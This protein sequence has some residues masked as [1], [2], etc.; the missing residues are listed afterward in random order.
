MMMICNHL[1]L[2]CIIWNV[3]LSASEALIC[4]F[5]AFE[6]D[7]LCLERLLLPH[8][9]TPAALFAS[10]ISW[11]LARR[12][13]EGLWFSTLDDFLEGEETW[14]TSGSDDQSYVRDK[15]HKEQETMLIRVLR[16]LQLIHVSDSAWLEGWLHDR[17]CTFWEDCTLRRATS[18]CAM[19]RSGSA[20]KGGRGA[21]GSGWCIILL[22]LAR[23]LSWVC[24]SPFLCVFSCILAVW[25]TLQMHHMP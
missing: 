14:N 1:N 24:R 13:P 10:Q 4:R 23:I 3:T 16:K 5:M 2:H 11:H 25:S 20:L 17:L 9:R 18:W 8:A 6:T 12:Q 21:L 15:V 19:V 7:K 22:F